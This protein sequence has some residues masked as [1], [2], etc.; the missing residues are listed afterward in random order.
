LIPLGGLAYTPDLGFQEIREL[1]P[2]EAIVRDGV[3]I[4]AVPVQHFS[5]RYGF[6][7]NWMQDRGYTGYVIEYRGYGI[8]IGGDTGYHPELFK[9][10]G[11]RFSIDVAVLPIAPGS[12][13]SLGSRVHAGPR[14]ALAICQDLGA[15]FLVPMHYGTLFYGSNQDPTYAVEHL[16][17]AA[18]EQGLSDRIV[19]LEA[20][21]QRILAPKSHPATSPK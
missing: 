15:R 6:D 14:G 20:G 12:T 17:V 10:T 21:E 16:R 11:R 9:E 7:R 3:R 2:W 1:G 8:F 18:A 19:D 4:T 13:R 5:G